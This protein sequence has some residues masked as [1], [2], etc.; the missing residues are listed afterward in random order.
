VP[1]A[2]DLVRQVWDEARVRVAPPGRAG[3]ETLAKARV[4]P[5]PEDPET[6]FI[7]VGPLAAD[8]AA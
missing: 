5:A 3:Q 8:R 7:E 6:V 4:I 1:V 2:S